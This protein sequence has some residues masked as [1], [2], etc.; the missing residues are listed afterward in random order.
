MPRKFDEEFR[1]QAVGMILDNPGTTIKQVS[2]E[3]GVGLSTL[4]KWLK[5][6][7]AKTEGTELASNEREELRRLR[8]ENQKLKLERELLKKAAVFFANNG[9]S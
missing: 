4:D 8:A 5:A 2:K 9:S 6:A 7:R 3:L 1:N